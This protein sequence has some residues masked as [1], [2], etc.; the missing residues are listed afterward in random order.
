MKFDKLKADVATVSDVLPP[1]LAAFLIVGAVL[2]HRLSPVAGAVGQ[3]M[4][5]SPRPMC[6]IARVTSTTSQR[7]S[8]AKAPVTK[9]FTS[10]ASA[11]IFGALS[12]QIACNFAQQVLDKRAARQT[13]QFE[14]VLCGLAHDR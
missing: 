13:T 6:F 10:A 14:E 11:K 4:W 12:D 8:R 1:G 9:C 3:C 7:I 5:C 2:C